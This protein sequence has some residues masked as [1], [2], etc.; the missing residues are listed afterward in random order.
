M[1]FKKAKKNSINSLNNLSTIS[2]N[3]LVLP[4]HLSALLAF[5]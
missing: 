1:L 3:K 5:F 2:R 4:I